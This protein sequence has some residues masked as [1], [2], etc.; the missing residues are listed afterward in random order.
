[1]FSRQCYLLMYQ[2]TFME[3]L[4]SK[5]SKATDNQV[6]KQ[7]YQLSQLMSSFRKFYV[8]Y[9]DIVSKYKLLLG[10]MLTYIFWI[11]LVRSFFNQQIVCELSVYPITTKKTQRVWLVSKWCSLL[12]PTY[13]FSRCPCVFRKLLYT[14][15]F[16][17]AFDH[18]SSSRFA[19]DA[20]VVRLVLRLWLSVCIM[21][22]RLT[23]K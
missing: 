7:D 6:G 1:M 16:E 13:K 2:Y 8:Q 20:E 17:H 19:L 4:S 23:I 14:F 9:K 18:I 5:S 22:L 10:Q 21:E 15:V 3:L 11:F 12:H